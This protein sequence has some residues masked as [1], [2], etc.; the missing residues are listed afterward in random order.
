M[1]A[2]GWCWRW[3]CLRSEKFNGGG[4]TGASGGGGGE[5]PLTHWKLIV[6]VNSSP[7]WWS[8]IIVTSLEKE[9]HS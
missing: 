9:T 8:I 4:K 7:I 5:D 2:N 3:W 6:P 1:N